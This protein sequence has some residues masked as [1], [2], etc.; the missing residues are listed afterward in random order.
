[1]HFQTIDLTT[2]YGYLNAGVYPDYNLGTGEFTIEFWVRPDN[3]LANKTIFTLAGDFNNT[4]HSMKLWVET[5]V[6]S[7]TFNL[8]IS[9]QL[10]TVKTLSYEVSGSGWDDPHFVSIERQ[11]QTLFMYMD[12]QLVASDTNAFYNFGTE[13]S[14]VDLTIGDS[15]EGYLGDIADFRLTRGVARHAPVNNVDTVIA[16][17]FADYYLGIRSEDIN[18][19]GSGFVN[20]VNSPATEEHVNGRLYDTLDIRVFSDE[21]LLTVATGFRMFKDMLEN[22]SIYN[23]SR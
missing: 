23:Y 2:T 13:D 19:A 17:D 14:A 7:N 4:T 6:S 18:V 16:S 3:T 11:R 9:T 10:G 15:T 12:G 21:S 20:N 5:G 1:M 8:D 22:W